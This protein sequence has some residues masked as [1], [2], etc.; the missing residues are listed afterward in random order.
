MVKLIELRPY[1]AIGMR[2]RFCHTQFTSRDLARKNI[3]IASIKEYMAHNDCLQFI[4]RKYPCVALSELDGK[5][6]R[7]KVELSNVHI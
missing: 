6:Q 4:L 1:D 5:L 2:C 3:M 7:I